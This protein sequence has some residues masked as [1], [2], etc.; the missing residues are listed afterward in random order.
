MMTVDFWRVSLTESHHRSF[1]VL[2]QVILFVT[3]NWYQ[4]ML[5]HLSSPKRTETINAVNVSL[6]W[7]ARYANEVRLAV[8]RSIAGSRHARSCRVLASA[9]AVAVLDSKRGAID[10]RDLQTASSLCA[11]ERI[12]VNECC[13]CKLHIAVL[14]LIHLQAHR[15]YLQ[16]GIS[17]L[18]DG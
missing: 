5:S 7:I 16:L 8:A 6:L 13:N 14:V 4:L 10:V 17:T 3:F 12:K 18:S 11:W 1:R 15:T 9:H 2:Q